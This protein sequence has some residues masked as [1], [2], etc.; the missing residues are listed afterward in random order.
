[1]RSSGLPV[2]GC[3]ATIR[4][5]MRL[6]RLLPLL[7][8]SVVL[9]TGCKSPCLQLAEKLCECEFPDNFQRERCKLEWASQANAVDITSDD[10]EVCEGLI[11]RCD[12]ALLETPE[13]K[14]AC[15]LAR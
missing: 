4:G 5:L 8:F 10:E 11:D 6:R 12:C 2:T 14:K 3:I 7:A 9:A 15:G 13:G 1:M